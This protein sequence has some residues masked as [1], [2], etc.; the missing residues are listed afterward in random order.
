VNEDKEKNLADILRKAIVDPTKSI[1]DILVEVKLKLDAKDVRF[2]PRDWQ[3]KAVVFVPNWIISGSLDEAEPELAR[4]VYYDPNELNR[5]DCLVGLVA[6]IARIEEEKAK[7]NKDKQ[8]L[9]KL[10][11]GIKW[12]KIGPKKIAFNRVKDESVFQDLMGR[13]DN[14]IDD[15]NKRKKRWNDYSIRIEELKKSCTN[16]EDFFKKALNNEAPWLKEKNAKQKKAQW[17]QL[18]DF[19]NKSMEGNEVR[20]FSEA[21]KKTVKLQEIS[22]EQLE[23]YKKESEIPV[24]EIAVPVVT[25]GKFIGVLNFHREEK[26]NE[27]D[28]ELARTYAA[29][30]AVVYLNEQMNLFEEFQSIAQFLTAESNFEIIASEIAKGIRIALRNGLKKN[31]VFPL[32]YISNLPIGPSDVLTKDEFI[33]RWKE[34]YQQREKPK[35]NDLEDIDRW[36]TENRLGPIHIRPNGLGEKIINKYMKQL[37]KEKQPKIEDRFI[38]SPN[39]DN[40]NSETGSRSAYFQE[41]KTTGCLPLVFKKRVHG[42]LYVHCKRRHFFTQAEINALE[43]FAVQAAIAINNARLYGPRYETLYG[44]KLLYL[45]KGEQQE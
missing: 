22:K 12:N 14:R 30:L 45:L 43:T 17:E 5:K 39:V 3:D 2:R 38:V 40:P 24:C 42:L 25:K 9:I 20:E 34:T 35:D 8:L 23:I 6:R 44:N 21:V 11:K 18:V 29:Q 41:I 7:K 16:K 27:Y 32:L 15:L 10:N 31:E 28:K 36:E 13:F 37:R 33:N 26:F 4:R 1:K 19:L